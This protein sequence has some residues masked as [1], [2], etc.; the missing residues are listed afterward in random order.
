METNKRLCKVCNILKD[1]T[2]SGLYPDGKNK[3]YID[4][5]GKLWNGSVCGP[6]NVQRSY[7]NMKKLRSKRKENEKI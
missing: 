3:K 1:R 7:N 4:D 6:C 5:S 2:E